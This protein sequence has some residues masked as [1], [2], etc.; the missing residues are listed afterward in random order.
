M[1]STRRA[2]RPIVAV[3]VTSVLMLAGARFIGRVAA[4]RAPAAGAGGDAA[5]QQAAAVP[6]LTF[7]STLGD[8]SPPRGKGGAKGT[9]EA[10]LRAAP[11][12]IVPAEGIYVVQVAAGGD[13]ARAK[14][15]RDRL[16]SKGYPAAV[17]QDEGGGLWRVRV[18]R[19]K[20]R[21]PAEAMAER[22][23]KETGLQ[24]WVLREGAR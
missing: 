18:G 24:P 2:G 11:G 9:G 16:A 14:R 20:D 19:W 13:E 6:D 1:S 17:I 22:I 15:V 12:D 10:A 7:Y 4:S 3:L 23:R 8:A 21:G 5:T